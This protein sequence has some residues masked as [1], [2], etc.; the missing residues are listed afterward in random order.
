M[1]PI[2]RRLIRIGVGVLVTGGLILTGGLL[3]LSGRNQSLIVIVGLLTVA[4]ASIP[5]ILAYVAHRESSN[6]R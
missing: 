3:L 1:H 5:L 4:C 6:A 2:V